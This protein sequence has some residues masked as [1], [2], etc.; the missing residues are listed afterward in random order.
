MRG[1]LPW[2][3]QGGEN[4]GEGA[5]GEDRKLDGPAQG[6]TDWKEITGVE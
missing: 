4:T 2:N 5:K 1:E 6:P 3:E